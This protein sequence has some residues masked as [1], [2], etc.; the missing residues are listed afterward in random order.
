MFRKLKK[1]GR[2][3]KPDEEPLN[4]FA[5]EYDFSEYFENTH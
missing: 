4:D 5:G 1:T 2:L 3:K